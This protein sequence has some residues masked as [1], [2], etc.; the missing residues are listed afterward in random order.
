VTGMA[1]RRGVSFRDSAVT[2]GAMVGAV[3][4]VAVGALVMLDPRAQAFWGA[5]LSD[6]GTIARAL[7]DQ[8]PRPPWVR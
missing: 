4:V 1:D 3:A 5:K 2:F 7:A 8:L 6:L